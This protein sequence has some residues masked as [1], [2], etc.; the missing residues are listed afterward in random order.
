M[1]RWARHGVVVGDEG[2]SICLPGP[3]SGSKKED[4]GSAHFASFHVDGRHGE[5]G[6]ELVGNTSGP[7]PLE[8]NLPTRNSPDDLVRK[9]QLP[10]ERWL[11]ASRMRD[12]GA[13]RITVRIPDAYGEDVLCIGSGTPQRD[14]RTGD[15]G[16][17][18]LERICR[19]FARA[20]ETPVS[21]PCE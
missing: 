15:A 6:I 2:F 21:K 12:T 1:P 16:F 17:E 13:P 19:S 7:F 14:A 5:I 9:E 20:A 11:I 3:P 10:N 8:A 18:D 4:L